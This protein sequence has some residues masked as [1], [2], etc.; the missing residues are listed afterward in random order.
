MNLSSDLIGFGGYS[1]AALIY[2]VTA[3]LVAVAA[4]RYPGARWFALALGTVGVWSAVLAYGFLVSVNVA[5]IADAFESLRMVACLVFLAG[6]LSGT[7]R[8]RQGRLAI[9]GFLIV[10]VLTVLVEAFKHQS[11]L[12]SYHLGVVSK[13]IAS[14]VGIVLIENIYRNTRPEERWDNKYLCIGFGSL[15]TLELFLY[16]DALLYQTMSWQLFLLR[17]VALV[18]IFPLL[19]IASARSR[20]WQANVA[21]SQSGVFYSSTLLA[22]GCYI[23]MMAAVGFYLREYGGSWGG[24]AQISFLFAAFVLL[25]V[26]LTSGRVRARANLFIRS[27]FFKYRHDYRLEWQNFSRRISERDA[28]DRLEVRVVKA[29]ADIFDC[30]AGGLWLNANGQLAVTA[31]WNMSVPSI[32]RSDAGALISHMT[33]SGTAVDVRAIIDGREGAAALDLPSEIRDLSRPWLL[34]PLLHHGRLQGLLIVSEPRAPREIDWE[35]LELLKTIGLVAASYVAE[36]TAAERLAEVEEFDKFNRRSAFLLHDLKNLVSQLSLVSSNI[37]RHGHEEAFRQDLASTIDHVVSKM[38]YLTARISPG[39]ELPA[40]PTQVD[41]AILLGS[42]DL[43]SGNPL[44]TLRVEND[45]DDYTVT[46]DRDRLNGLFN[47]LVD[48]ALEA[49]ESQNDGAV[50]I[51]IHRSQAEVIVEVTDN[52]PGMDQEFVRTELFKPFRST[53]AT[54]MGLGAFQCRAYARELRG[55][56]VVVTNP[57][58]GTT[59]R[60]VLPASAR[61]DDDR[62]STDQ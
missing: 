6:L 34:I 16:A 55:D 24:I 57:G 22:S 12:V 10:V 30:P 52:G 8:R 42:L 7:N 27:N 17:G 29:I 54:G 37:E 11:P 33:E 50:R 2:C 47:H 19:L 43:V 21:L 13:L 15:F 46:A 18:L 20:L 5:S 60:V 44:V 45:S 3:G 39:S 49:V 53:K 35:D 58:A 40:E 1:I 31:T 51:G 9:G 14:V 23:V 48:N 38:K 36:R 62:G 4:G 56:F 59:I 28:F 61:G 26:L 32:S 41:L 25:A